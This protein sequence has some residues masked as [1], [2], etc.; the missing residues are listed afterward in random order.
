[1]KYTDDFDMGE[2]KKPSSR[3]FPI[4]L[5]VC[6]IAVCGIAVATFVNQVSLD[7]PEDSQIPLTTTTTTKAD[8]Q[9]VI[10]AT[11]IPDDRTTTT[12]VV[13][14][15]STAAAKELFVFPVSNRIVSAF[16]DEHVYSETLGEWIT[17]NGVDF[18]AKANDAVKAVANGT[19]KE[20]LQDALWGNV[21]VLS[22]SGNVMT[23]YCGVTAEGV[24]EGTEV[25][26]GDTIGFVSEI[27]AEVVMPAHLHLEMSVNGAFID[28]LTMIEGETV[29]VT[30]AP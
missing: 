10:P 29:T 16:S 23:R 3:V 11:D 25:K 13:T 1:M 20:V 15:A 14:T 5:A 8:Q 9:V 2:E 22:H 12:T 6:L 26:A 21:I 4:V 28:P 19:V 18:E 27:P 7:E 24:Q 30:P 17:H